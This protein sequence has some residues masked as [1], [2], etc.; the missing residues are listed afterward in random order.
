M[1]SSMSTRVECES[2]NTVVPKDAFE[3]SLDSKAF[4][5][6]ILTTVSALRITK[7][8][9]DGS[10]QDSSSADSVYTSVHPYEDANIKIEP[11]SARNATLIVKKLFVNYMYQIDAPRSVICHAGTTPVMYVNLI[12]KRQLLKPGTYK[13]T[14]NSILGTPEGLLIVNLPDDVGYVK[15]TINQLSE[16]EFKPMLLLLASKP[17]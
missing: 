2:S 14:D 16:Q 13:L 9:Y 5:F 11:S 12:L 15:P 1:G 17:I 4:K 3:L 6:N 8:K 10:W 7:L